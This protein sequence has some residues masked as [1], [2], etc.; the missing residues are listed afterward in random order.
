MQRFG[1][2]CELKAAVFA[3][4]PDHLSRIDMVSAWAI[5]VLGVTHVSSFF[6][7]PCFV[8]ADLY[9][10]DLAH[11][12]VLKVTAAGELTVL[13][14]YDGQ[15]NGLALHPDGRLF[16]ADY[17]HGI[18]A[19]DLAAPAPTPAPVPV[20]T[21]FRME[22]FRGV[23][24]L[25][26]SSSGELYFSDQGQSDLRFPTGRVFRW[27]ADDGLQLLL[28]GLASPN[29][30]AL[31]ADERT[32]FVAITRGN[33]VLR[34]PLRN[35]AQLGKVGVHLHLS[36]GSGGPDGLAVDAA[37]RLAVAHYGL[38]GVWLFDQLGF[39][40]AF[41]ETPT[42]LGTTNVAFGPDGKTLCITEASS[43]AV[44]LADLQPLGLPFEDRSNE[45][46]GSKE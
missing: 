37:G 12:R 46:E 3:R 22:P 17:R 1:Q 30:M 16:V 36:G 24:D 27:T 10:S 21:G 5:E 20:V 4:L 38:G 7:G 39:L 45:R 41:V 35:G 18:L 44:L 32:L 40:Q 23:S 28:E 8:G 14:S 9:V 31:S 43:G 34:V 19:L 33:C 25:V 29:G 6:E 13:V 11:G 15:P 2:V 26:F 42:G